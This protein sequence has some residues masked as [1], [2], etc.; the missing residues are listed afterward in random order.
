MFLS[1]DA[2]IRAQNEKDNP[3]AKYRPVILTEEDSGTALRWNTKGPGFKV[4][5]KAEEGGQWEMVQPANQQKRHLSLTR[6]KLIPEDSKK[7]DGPII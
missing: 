7:P 1:G 2:P 6:T 3:K 5:L 4:R